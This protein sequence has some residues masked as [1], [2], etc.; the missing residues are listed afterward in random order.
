MTFFAGEGMAIDLGSSN[1]TIYLENEGIVL[2][3]PTNVLALTLDPSSVLAVGGD[4][5]EMVGRTD[6][7]A[8]LYAPVMDGAVTD[9][10]MA[11]LVMVALAE[12]ATGRRRP[13]DKA[14]LLVSMSQGLTKVEREA[15][16]AAVRMTGAKRSILIKTPLAAALGAGV[17][18]D[19]PRGVMVVVMGGGVTEIAVVSMGAIVAARS[20]RSGGFSLD[21]AIVRYVRREKGVIIGLSTAEDLKCD[22]GSAV[23][24]DRDEADD[25]DSEPTSDA[26]ESAEEESADDAAPKEFEGQT[27]VLKGRDAKTG[28]P[29][30]VNMTTRDIALALEEPVRQLVDALS[31][32][33]SRV[34]PDLAGDILE[35]GVCLSG[36]GALLKGLA[37]LLAEKTGV[38][39][40][41]SEHPHEDV[42][43]GLGRLASD[44]KLLKLALENGSAEE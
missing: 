37:G 19:Q 25:P 39:V 44:E 3:E 22:I 12:K 10:D 7:Q 13:M 16:G 2:R 6:E 24:P 29:K 35:S 34:P 5:Y 23:K 38:P 17:T 21:E 36:G 30:S 14:Q 9:T 8:R 42:I 11:A 18:V 27:V 32:A 28:K 43:L 4:A 33:L 26:Q 31:D 1:T 15:L 20:M 41:V 40:S